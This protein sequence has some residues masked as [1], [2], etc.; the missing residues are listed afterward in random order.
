MSE[1]TS[2]WSEPGPQEV[3]PGVHRIPLPLPNDGL[4][5]V[6]VYAIADGEDVVLI[7]SGWA[8]DESHRQLA[9]ALDRIGYGLEHVSQ[10]LITHSHAD[11]YTQAV[12]IR[13]EHATPI[14]VGEGE[15]T[16]LEWIT[17][18]RVRRPFSQF[19]QLHRAGADDVVAEL[20]AL[21]PNT[22][23]D[24]NTWALPDHWLSGCPTITLRTRTLRAIPTPGH[25]RGHYV[26]WDADAG[27]LF[28]GD[29]VLPHITPSIGFEAVPD[30]SP[31]ADY[32][33]SLLLVRTMPDARLLP[34]HGPVG[35]NVH[36]R[37][38][39]LLDHHATR[40]DLTLTAV[41]KGASTSR[42]AAERLGWTRRGRA[43]A[44]MDVFNRMLATLET[45]AHLDVLA[46]RGLLS[47]T[48]DADG[49][50]RYSPS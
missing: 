21:P 37:V 4:R 9:G 2:D 17:P 41:A 13:R 40:L 3:A 28:A 27:L 50:R 15:R 42:E 6:N 38:D 35:M 49:V 12:R 10:F 11:H 31:L 5:A 7:D 46:E 32:L 8:T 36:E 26:F 30:A 44:E 43:F 25:T 48:D 18:E 23:V 20:E 39:E 45:A 16:T 29:H 1:P 34:A 24:E 33:T 14:S 47:V 19:A 22:E